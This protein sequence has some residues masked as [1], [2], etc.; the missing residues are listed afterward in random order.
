MGRRV[1]VLGGTGQIGRALVPLLLSHGWEVTAAA[2][3][4]ASP[5]SDLDVRFIEVDRDEGLDLRDDF[6]A[7]VDV[8]PYTLEHARQ[9]LRLGAGAIV[10]ISSASVYTD[11]DG[12][13]LDEAKEEKSF[14]Q[15]PVPIPETQATV[16]PSDATYS[17]QKSALERTLLEQD[18]TPAIVV[19]PCAVYGPGGEFTRE[20][21]FVKRILDGRRYVVLPVGGRN[22]FHPTSVHNIAELIRVALDCPRSGV[23]N[24]GDPDPPSTLEI[25]R[26]IARVLDHQWMECLL[27]GAAVD[28]VGRTP[29]GRFE[30]PIVLD[31]AKAETELGYRPAVAYPE[32]VAET[33]RWIVEARPP[34]GE[35]M[36]TFFDY[37]A[38]DAL[39]AATAS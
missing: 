5:V 11:A 28:G 26:V 30:A 3:H 18:E 17:T 31:M 25:G 14:P 12:R 10:A 32:A 34:L 1:F 15:F 38:E 4:R 39:L 16:A 13:T 2:R 22:V 27:P 7:V 8:V 24:C 23:F 19:R 37:G 36:E 9:L 35:Y 33:C 20:Q 29:W 21:F 6:D